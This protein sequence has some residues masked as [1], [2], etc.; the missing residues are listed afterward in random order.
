MTVSRVNQSYRREKYF[1][2]VEKWHEF[3]REYYMIR[4]MTG[5][6]LV[7]IIYK[8]ITASRQNY[9]NDCALRCWDMF[10]NLVWELTALSRIHHGNILRQHLTF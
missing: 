4:R 9:E 7:I 2:F 5:S 1:Y 3:L 8:Q 10:G 6:F